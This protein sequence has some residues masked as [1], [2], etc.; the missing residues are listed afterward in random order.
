MMITYD[1]KFL[2]CQWKS[3][4]NVLIAPQTEKE[5]DK[6]A[7]LLDVLIDEVNDN[8]E[9]ELASL[10]RIVE[11][12]ICYYDSLKHSFSEG[13]PV[14]CLKYFMELYGLTPA[15]LPEIGDEDT[16]NIVLSGK[17][18]ANIEQVDK[19]G[20]RFKAEPATFF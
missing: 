16:V 12:L 17:Y 8:K 19:L 15:D 10:L 1:M 14:N 4:A 11:N 2:A 13:S 6:L 18:N 9:H 5:Y 3:L 20:K 7:N